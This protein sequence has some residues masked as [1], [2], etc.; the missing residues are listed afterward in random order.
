VQAG[1]IK[2]A[3]NQAGH[4]DPKITM[5]TYTHSNLEKQAEAMEVLDEPNTDA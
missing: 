3:Q 5:Q 4:S 1:F 2:E